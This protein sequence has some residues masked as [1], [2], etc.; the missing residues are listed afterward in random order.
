[1]Y[2]L[3]EIELFPKHSSNPA[4]GLEGIALLNNGFYYTVTIFDNY[5]DWK[6]I[7]VL[8][9]Q[10]TNEELEAMESEL[11]NIYK[12]NYSRIKSKPATSPSLFHIPQMQVERPGRD[13]DLPDQ[14]GK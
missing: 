10:Y 7:D 9:D 12:K 3:E 2:L 14:Q 11:L 6:K 13:L 5:T 1:M 4:A 8:E